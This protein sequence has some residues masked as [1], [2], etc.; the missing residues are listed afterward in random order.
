[1]GGSIRL[2]PKHGVNP[3]IPVCFWC[4]KQKNEIVLLG[5]SSKRLTGHDKAPMSIVLDY[6]PRDECKAQ[7]ERGVTL[8]E[9]VESPHDERP[10]IQ[11]GLWPTGRWVVVTPEAFERVFGAEAASDVLRAGKAFIAKD[12]FEQM[13][14]D[15]VPRPEG[16]D[17]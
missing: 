1:M 6:E 7:M 8:A 11:D 17:E 10:P 15:R 14:L 16:D 12:A 4:G 2:H 5:A 13:G 9:C 3:T